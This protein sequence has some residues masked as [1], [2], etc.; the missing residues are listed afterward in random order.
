MRQSVLSLAVVVGIVLLGRTS[1]GQIKFNLGFKLENLDGNPLACD[2]KITGSPGSKVKFNVF[3]TLTQSD[4]EAGKGASGFSIGYRAENVHLLGVPGASVSNTCSDAAT[5]CPL[6]GGAPCPDGETSATC[7]NGDQT[8]AASGASCGSGEVVI[9]ITEFFCSASTVD[10][11]KS[12]ESGPLAGSPQ[13]EGYVDGLAFLIGKSIAGNSTSTVGKVQAEVTIPDSGSAEAR[14]FWA[15]G[16]QGSGQPVKNG[17]TSGGKT[18]D[19]ATGRL[20]LGECRLTLE[21]L[22]AIQRPGDADQNGELELTDVQRLLAHLFHSD[23]PDLPCENKTIYSPGNKKLF[24]AN[25]DGEIDISDPIHNLYHIF[26]GGPAHVLGT[27]CVEIPGCP[28]NPL[29]L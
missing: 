14:L 8:T 18:I 10:P 9:P 21:V 28:P 3:G 29:C 23:P 20:T 1:F 7:A 11:A 25:G 6:L 5:A 22:R 16:L 26:L 13:G 2:G 24:D 15:D 4:F 19:V 12:P 17:I 27:A